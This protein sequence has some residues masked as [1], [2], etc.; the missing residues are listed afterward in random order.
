VKPTGRDLI[1]TLLRTLAA[2][3]ERLQ[4]FQ[5]DAQ[6]DLD[7]STLAEARRLKPR[8]KQMDL[9]KAKKVAL[10]W[11]LAELERTEPALMARYNRYAKAIDRLEKLLDAT[12]AIE[13]PRPGPVSVQAYS[14][15]AGNYGSQGPG[16]DQKYLRVRLG[17]AVEGL[18]RA[19]LAATVEEFEGKATGRVL[20]AV[21]DAEIDGAIARHHASVGLPLR[22]AVRYCWAHGCQPRVFWSFLPY[23]YEEQQGLDYFGGEKRRTA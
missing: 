18:K 3:R 16:G 4:R 22:E 7:A 1:S 10:P 6:A 20:V 9:A 17:L 19:G 8:A 13:R 21:E 2:T 5:A 15:Y 14:M 23:G 12:A 11:L